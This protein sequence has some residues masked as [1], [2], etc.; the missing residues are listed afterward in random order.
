MVSLILST[1]DPVRYQTTT[2]SP[3][4]R[5]PRRGRYLVRGGSEVLDGDW[6]PR[7]L[8]ILPFDSIEK[9]NAWRESPEY[10][11]AKQVRESCARANMIVVDGM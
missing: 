2:G 10:A 4:P 8:T 9:A 6:T 5:L 11:G 1:T 3:R 7:R